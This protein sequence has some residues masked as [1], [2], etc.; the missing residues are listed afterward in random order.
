MK[1]RA[2]VARAGIGARGEE[3]GTRQKLVRR[4]GMRKISPAELI[5]IRWDFNDPG[6]W[7]VIRRF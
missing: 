5:T 4:G 2:K 3:E 7:L 6:R 1:F